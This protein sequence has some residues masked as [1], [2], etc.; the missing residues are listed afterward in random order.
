MKIDYRN[1]PYM[2]ARYEVIDTETGE[3]LNHL[4]IYFADD[5]AG[6]IRRNLV[7]DKG[8]M[9]LDKRGKLA[10]VEEK[11]AILIQPRMVDAPT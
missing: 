4:R 6:V 5:E 2:A 3:N 9:Y 7:N 10:E 8:A 11:R 1:N